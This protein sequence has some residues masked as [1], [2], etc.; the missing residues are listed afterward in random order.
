MNI[1]DSES[2]YIKFFLAYII[3][4]FVFNDY[5]ETLF[6]IGINRK[7]WEYYN[8]FTAS[9][10]FIKEIIKMSL[11]HGTNGKLLEDIFKDQLENNDDEKQ[12]KKEVKYEDKYLDEI[13]KMN[14]EFEFTE[15]EKDLE[16]EK[17]YEFYSS[18]KN[19]YINSIIKY[20]QQIEEK[21]K[22]ILDIE[23]E[24]YY[25]EED[26]TYGTAA[27]E[28]KK[29]SY[30]ESIESYKTKI[31]E[32]QKILLNDENNIEKM[33]KE[34]AK[35]YV[36]DIKLDKM[37]DNYIMEKTPLG[38]VLMVYNNKRESFVYY[39]DNTI[40]Y[41]Y[42]EIV[43]RKYVKCFDCRPIYVDMEEELRLYEEKIEKDNIEK[44]ERKKEENNKKTEENQSQNNNNTE[45]KK[46]VFAKFKSYNKEAGSGRVNT[47]PPPKNS[48]PNINISSDSSNTNEKILLKER[49]NRYTYEGK[50][51]N[52]NFLK[53]VDRK[54]VDKK[55]SI[56]FAEFKKMQTENKK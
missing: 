5:D 21:E 48:I 1:L 26:V 25:N 54:I 38:N 49:A 46:N 16:K 14:K 50:F 2:I 12:S 51:A 47:A 33:A 40:P 4:K 15:E 13:R 56:S 34:Q 31:E 37:K 18:I 44:E 11:D 8:F 19:D 30:L 10:K 42:L 7:I 43:A 35:Q 32:V 36:I 20:K 27:N 53:K 28:T 17:F 41:R 39:S 9:F 24:V 22:E 45:K 29:E 52:F 23:D 55:Y 3:L 6:F